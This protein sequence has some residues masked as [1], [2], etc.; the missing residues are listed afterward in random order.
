MFLIGTLLWACKAPKEEN[1]VFGTQDTGQASPNDS[2]EPALDSYDTA[3]P[4]TEDTT[5]EDTDSPP[6]EIDIGV[7][8]ER[9]TTIAPSQN[10]SSDFGFRVVNIQDL[11]GDGL[12]EIALSAP[13]YSSPEENIQGGAVLIYNGNIEKEELGIED[14][15]AM[16]VSDMT[17]SYLGQSMTSCDVNQDGIKELYIAS[18]GY[19]IEGEAL[20]AVHRFSL[21]LSGTIQSQ[22]AAQTLLGPVHNSSFGSSIAC[23]APNHLMAISA[24]YFPHDDMNH[25]GAAWVYDPN[26]TSGSIENYALARFY[27]DHEGQHFGVGLSFGDVNGDG[28]ADIFCEWRWRGPQWNRLWCYGRILWSP[29]RRLFS[30]TRM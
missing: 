1:F 25:A 28:L 22:H 18:P 30:R 15:Q 9:H 21:P 19:N 26:N 7:L 23:F 13:T 17:S 10:N 11:N 6:L 27:G 29:R 4:S 5:I 14:A 12:S 16:I 24:S 2:S 20:G 8:G 3:E